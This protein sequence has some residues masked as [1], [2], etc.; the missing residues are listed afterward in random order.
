VRKCNN[1]GTNFVL[2]IESVKM[3]REPKHLVKYM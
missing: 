1:H 2:R 3:N